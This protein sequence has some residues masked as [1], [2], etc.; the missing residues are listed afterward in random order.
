MAGSRATDVCEPRQDR[1]VAAVSRMFRVPRGCLVGAGWQVTAWEERSTVGAR[2]LI[3]CGCRPS[4]VLRR[5]GFFIRFVAL[6]SEG[7]EMFPTFKRVA[8]DSKREC[9]TGNPAT[10]G[11]RS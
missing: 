10:T 4:R 9:D 5:A 1:E 8:S 6:L 3:E 11:T 2:P 7:M